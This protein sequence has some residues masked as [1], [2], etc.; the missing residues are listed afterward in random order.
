[1]YIICLFVVSTKFLHLVF[2]IL[3]EWSRWMTLFRTERVTQAQ[4]IDKVA[5]VSAARP[6]K[7]LT[8]RNTCLIVFPYPNKLNVKVDYNGIGAFVPQYILSRIFI[9]LLTFKRCCTI[10]KKTNTMV[11]LKYFFFYWM[12]KDII[13]DG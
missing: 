6:P 8:I 11:N 2:C 7:G 13:R 1:M 12:V 4:P 5:C 10:S 9:S 3:R